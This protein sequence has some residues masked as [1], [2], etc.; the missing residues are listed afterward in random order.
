MNRNPKYNWFFA[1]TFTF[2]VCFYP[3]SFFIF[4]FFYFKKKKKKKIVVYH[5]PPPGE[6]GSLAP[7]LVP[8][9][10][11]NEFDSMKNKYFSIKI[12]LILDFK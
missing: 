3:F 1:L 5:G 10:A 11:R 4:L 8:A 6:R 2:Y 12:E 7:L 9:A